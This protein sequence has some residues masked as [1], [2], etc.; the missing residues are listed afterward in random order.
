MFGLIS[1]NTGFPPLRIIAF[2]VETKDNEGSIT[3]QFFT[4]IRDN[5]R[6]NAAVPL[7]T[8][9]QPSEPIYFL[10]FSSNFKTLPEPD[11]LAQN[12]LSRTLIIARFS[13]IPITGSNSFI[14]FIIIFACVLSP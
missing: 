13:F 14:L 5:D 1:A 10:N 4:S 6:F 11:P 3:S 12:L 9:T 2:A 8:A 7:F